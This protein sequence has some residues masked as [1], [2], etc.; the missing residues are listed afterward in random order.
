MAKL[1]QLAVEIF[2]NRIETL[3]KLL[4]G[5]FAYWIMSRVVVHVWKEDSLRERR[6]DVLPG[7][8]ISVTASPNLGRCLECVW[9]E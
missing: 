1:G 8:A 5:D 3:L 6:F 2:I 7:A 4:F 9:P